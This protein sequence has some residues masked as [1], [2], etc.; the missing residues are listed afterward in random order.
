MKDTDGNDR[1]PQP[2]QGLLIGIFLTLVIIFII[3]LFI[4]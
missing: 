4:R 3:F 2:I 1:V